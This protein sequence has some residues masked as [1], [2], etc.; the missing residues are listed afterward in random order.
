MQRSPRFTISLLISIDSVV[1]QYTPDKLDWVTRYFLRWFAWA[2]SNGRNDVSGA[3]SSALFEVTLV[4]VVAPCIA[5]FSCVLI[6]SLKWAP[7]LGSKWPGFSPKLTALIIGG[8]ALVAG[9]YLLGRRFG[10]YRDNR[11]AWAA[12]DTEAD[13]RLIFWQKFAIL[14]ICGLVVPLFALAATV[15]IL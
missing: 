6:T 7:F 12:F 15:W 8:V 14:S 11:A 13:H 1:T 2:Y 5:A 3:Y 9:G 10:R 4:T